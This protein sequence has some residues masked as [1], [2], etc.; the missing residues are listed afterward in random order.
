ME[1]VEPPPLRGAAPSLRGQGQ[2]WFNPVMPPPTGG[3]RGTLNLEV[4]LIYGGGEGESLQ[5][6]L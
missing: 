4:I 2:N 6:D 5:Y 3:M 1:P